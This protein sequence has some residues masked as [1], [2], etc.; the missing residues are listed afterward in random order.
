M[1]AI[2]ILRG[3]PVASC[4][5]NS[6]PVC[7]LLSVDLSVKRHLSPP[8][9]MHDISHYCSTTKAPLAEHYTVADCNNRTGRYF[10]CSVKIRSIWLRQR[11][12][13]IFSLKKLCTK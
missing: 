3:S 6:S 4:T 5:C 12:V 10:S 7:I 2:R 8:E 9:Y 1:V 11:E 13:R